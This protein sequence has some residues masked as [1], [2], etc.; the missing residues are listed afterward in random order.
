MTTKLP[1]FYFLEP[2]IQSYEW[3]NTEGIIQSFVSRLTGVQLEKKPMAELW[4]GDHVK[5]PSLIRPF[6]PNQSSSQNE[7]VALNKAILKNPSHF[8]GNL[9]NKGYTN[10]PFLFKI[11]DAAKPLSIQAHPDKKLAE[12]LH[13]LD[14]INYPDSNHKPEIAISL[15]KVEAMAGFRPLTEL[16]QELNRLQPLRNLLCQSD[17][18]F[19]IDS[20]EALHQAYSKLMLAQTELIES[21]ANQ[22]INILNQTQITERDQWF[23]KLIDFY[24]KKD[25]GVFAIYLFNYITLEKGQAIYLD[26]NQP[27]AYLKGEI[28][29][30][31]ASSDNVVRGGLTSNFK[32]IPTL[33]SMLSYE[34][35]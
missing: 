33:L 8:L 20:I 11:L 6:W 2:T 32:D 1:I 12:K 10:L 27:H 13:K 30:C 21:T 19:E 22:L 17:I 5:S 35:S 4:Q 15:N 18:D 31:M 25:S 26:A 9:Y 3:G 29:E 16:Q 24:G 14:P 34:T 7:A 28:L 23:L